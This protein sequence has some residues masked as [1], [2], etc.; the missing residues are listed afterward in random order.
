VQGAARPDQGGNRLDDAQ[1]YLQL[2][3]CCS[4]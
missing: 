4:S 3:C 1:G 2:P